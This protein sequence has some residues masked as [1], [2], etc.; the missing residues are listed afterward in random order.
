MDSLRK[1]FTLFWFAALCGLAGCTTPK[2]NRG[3]VS[4]ELQR[5][6]GF[7]LPVPSDASPGFPPS[8]TFEDGL[9]EDEVVTLALWKNAAFQELLADLGLSWADVV[10]AGMLPNPTL[11]MLLPIGA[12]PLE[13]TAK[14]PVESIWLRPR[15]LAAAKLDYD[16]TTQRLVQ[17]GLDLIRDARL[18]CIDLTLAD[19]RLELAQTLRVLA[20]GLLTQTQARLRSGEASELE[21]TSAQI[22][23]NQAREQS[24]RAAHDKLLALERV[25]S[26]VGLGMEP[27]TV[28]V[29]HSP[30]ALGY[31]PELN[32]LLTNALAARPDFYAA[33]LGLEA[34]GRRVG[35]AQ[36]EVYTF[37]AALNAKEVGNDFLTGPGLDVSIPIINQNQGGVALA[38]AKFQKASLQYVALR[39]RIALEVREAHTRFAQAQESYNSWQTRILPS[40]EE[41]VALAERSAAA[42]NETFRTVLEHGRKL[43]DARLK[44]A[45]AAAEL[46][47]ARAE[48]E[49]SVGQRL[50]PNSPPQP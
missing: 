22:E 13:L 47:R 46:R 19:E 43:A 42:G 8:V 39:D 7:E 11:S 38:K 6:T 40:L 48:L 34:A 3:A 50:P 30:L 25:R 9:S 18:A 41:A 5:R 32:L 45:T 23:V 36:S 15:R 35:L 29:H 28:D 26:L 31:V 16:R 14:Y 21:A 27:R 17:S 12:K 24:N 33:R 1:K 20:E 44:S 4:A 49:R 2:E 37:T 10:Q